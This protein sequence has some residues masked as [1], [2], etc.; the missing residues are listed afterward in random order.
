MPPLT[1]GPLPA[2]VYWRRR[3]FVLALAATLVFLVASVLTGGSDGQ[4]DVPVARQ[5]GNEVEPSQTITVDQGRK[6]RGEQQ[7]APQGRKGKRDLGPQQGPTFD[8]TLLAAEP[9]G[10]CEPADVRITPRVESAVAGKPVTIG[11]A[12]QTVQAEACYFRIGADKVTIKVTRGQQALWRS[13]HCP[14]AVPSTSVVVRRSIA[15]VVQM[16]WSPFP[17]GTRHGKEC[18]GTK[19]WLMPGD[20]TVTAAALGGE[21]G[22]SAF[23]LAA[24]ER[25]KIVKKTKKDERDERDKQDERDRK[26]RNQLDEET[27]QEEAQGAQDGEEPRR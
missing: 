16:E 14:G 5:A 3:F 12:L 11:L 18:P 19:D 21:P 24:P 6:A 26:S 27:A 10:N 8:P 4:D 13:S 15:T 17:E 25:E 2:G 23:T 9:S 7:S 1:R 22:E 20:Y